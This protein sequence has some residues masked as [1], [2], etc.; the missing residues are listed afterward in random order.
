VGPHGDADRRVAAAQLLDD[1]RVGHVV[2]PRP[3]VL[4]GHQHPE[5]PERRQLVDDLERELVALV[6]GRDLVA[7]LVLGE[8]PGDLSDL[9]LLGCQLEIHGLRSKARIGS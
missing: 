1:E 4:L 9:F 5:Q 3:A 8:L 2:E 7:Q 6:E